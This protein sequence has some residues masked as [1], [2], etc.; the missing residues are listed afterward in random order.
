MRRTVREWEKLWRERWDINDYADLDQV[1]AGTEAHGDAVCE[2]E[3]ILET[4]EGRIDTVEIALLDAEEFTVL[5]H[6][7]YTILELGRVELVVEVIASINTDPEDEEGGEAE[8]LPGST[9]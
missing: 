5:V 2:V 9:S 8:P 6:H 4:H 3:V 1:F 7:R